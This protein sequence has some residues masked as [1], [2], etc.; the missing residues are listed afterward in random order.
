M[1]KNKD[2]LNE[3]IYD[4]LDIIT[5]NSNRYKELSENLKDRLSGLTDSIEIL[6]GIDEINKFLKK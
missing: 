1:N 3:D 2:Y 5:E 4:S 6:S